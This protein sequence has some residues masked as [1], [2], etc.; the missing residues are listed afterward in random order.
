MNIISKN[1]ANEMLRLH[2]EIFKESILS[3]DSQQKL[4]KG[5]K[6]FF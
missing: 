6:T 3:E 4:E 5:K 2:K 1:P